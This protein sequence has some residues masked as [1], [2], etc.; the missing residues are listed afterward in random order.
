MSLQN[1]YGM[2]LL[3]LKLWFCVVARY[4]SCVGVADVTTP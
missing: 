4:W 1:V 3:A 2:F